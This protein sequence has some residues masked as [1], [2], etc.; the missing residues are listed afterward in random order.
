MKKSNLIIFLCFLWA[1]QS[2]A[3]TEYGIRAG[4]NYTTMFGK[5]VD[6]ALIFVDG[7]KKAERRFM[8]AYH[9]GAY[10]R[11]PINEQMY[12]QPE[13]M[14]SKKGFKNKITDVTRVGNPTGSEELTVNYFNE[15]FYGETNLLFGAR[16]NENWHFRIGPQIGYL[17][18][19]RRRVE[20][21]VQDFNTIDA[22]RLSANAIRTTLI[23]DFV[24]GGLTQEEAVA[25]Y[26][27]TIASYQGQFLYKKRRPA[28]G[29]MTGI[30][31]EFDFGL[32][33]NFNADFMLVNPYRMVASGDLKN[34]FG[35]PLK[36]ET[37]TIFR[38]LNFQLS[39]GYTIAPHTWYRNTH[40]RR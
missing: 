22:F 20:N 37:E 24:R 27:A 34:F 11:I 14:I 1:G 28:I 38:N 29:L 8:P 15:F 30:G 19:A 35:G 40:R 39:V 16:L 13:L 36:P 21:E 25:K 12:F 9:V 17:F 31:Y 23:D 4:L 5:F 26:N 32:S 6:S 3:Q 18:E 7:G 10:L 33:I 2:F